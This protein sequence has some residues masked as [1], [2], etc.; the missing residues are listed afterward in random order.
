[1]KFKGEN[2]SGKAK[3]KFDLVFY[4]PLESDV[5]YLLM[6]DHH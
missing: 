2:L 1:M 6:F 4:E 3:Y 5:L